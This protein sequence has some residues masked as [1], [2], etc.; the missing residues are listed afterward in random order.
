[1]R[2]RTHAVYLTIADV[3]DVLATSNADGSSPTRFVCRELI[4][5]ISIAGFLAGLQC[6][7][8]NLPPFGT[9]DFRDTP[10]RDRF[11]A[12]VPGYTFQCSGRVTWW[13]ACVQPGS[14]SIDQYY[15]RF[16][17][18][19]PTGI[20]GC[21]SLVDFNRPVDGNGDDGF[22]SPPDGTDGPLDRCVVLSVPEDQQIE[23]Q[24]G[25]VVGYY[26]DHLNRNGGIQWI[27]DDPNMV[28]VH[29]RDD[30]P[31]EDIKSQY[32]LGG[33]N[34]TNC[35]F[36]TSDDYSLSES[37]SAAP[38]INIT[39]ICVNTA[40]LATC[41]CKILQSQQ[42]QYPQPQSPHQ[43]SLVSEIELQ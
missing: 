42:Y 43:S 32:A 33:V 17:V 26:V 18:W 8:D 40:I 35:G 24:S 19:R 31:R 7:V 14:R 27:E 5:N 11:Q 39:G 12:I 38:I 41:H 21:Y 13:G 4:L 20:S 9:T 30:L 23:V 28:V 15:I 1:M 6:S 16:Q 22:L 37:D 34:P 29:Y 36:P 3:R 2:M 25:D 10:E